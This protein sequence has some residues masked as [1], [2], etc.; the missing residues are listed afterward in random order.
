MKVVNVQFNDPNYLSGEDLNQ[1]CQGLMSALV[2]RFRENGAEIK[3][4]LL[5]RFDNKV[6]VEITVL[7]DPNGVFVEER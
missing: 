7:S 4:K 1:K 6:Q 5:R 3:V 2:Q